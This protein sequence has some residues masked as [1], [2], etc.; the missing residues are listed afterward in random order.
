[1]SYSYAKRS[2][3][4]RKRPSGGGAGGWLAVMVL[5]VALGGLWWAKG[6]PKTEKTPEDITIIQYKQV[7]M[8]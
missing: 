8:A 1:M 6:L 7:T 5:A 4:R 3:P 2:F